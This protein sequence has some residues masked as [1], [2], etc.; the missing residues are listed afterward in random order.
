MQLLQSDAT[1]DGH[2]DGAQPQTGV[3]DASAGV[4]HEVAYD[5]DSCELVGRSGP[6]R[7]RSKLVRELLKGQRWRP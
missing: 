1:V 7:T 4:E 2:V 3:D 6:G 5:G